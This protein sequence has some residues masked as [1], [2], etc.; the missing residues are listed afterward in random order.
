MDLANI[1]LI[2]AILFGFGV[3]SLLSRKSLLGIIVSILNASFGVVLF[4]VVSGVSKNTIGFD[5]I[6]LAFFYSVLFLT[7]LI[8]GCVLVWKRF[9]ASDVHSLAE[10]N[11]LKN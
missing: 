8:V 5:S 10:G 2:A 4:V 1:A 3:A 7:Q 11:N 6:T 9:R